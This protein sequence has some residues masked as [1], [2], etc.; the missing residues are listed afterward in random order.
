VS[1]RRNSQFPVLTPRR[2][3]LKLRKEAAS[4]APLKATPPP[5][6]IA[7]E[8]KIVSAFHNNLQA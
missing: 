8:K 6:I 1:M 2:N 4:T 7:E 3:V 5:P